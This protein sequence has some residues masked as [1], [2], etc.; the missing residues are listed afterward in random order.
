MGRDK[1]TLLFQGEPLFRRGFALLSQVCSSVFLSCR[2]EQAGDELYQSHPLIVDS[3]PDKG[4]LG[5][6]ES[7]L[8]LNSSCAWLVLPC[9]LPSMK[10]TILQR[11]LDSRTPGFDAVVASHG[12]KLEPLVGV[13][14]PTSA[15]AASANLGRDELSMRMLLKSLNVLEMPF[16]D[17]GPFRNVNT[18]DDLEALTRHSSRLSE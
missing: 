15:S 14:E 11:L 6:L 13:Y 2:P 9:D 1:A 5:A 17:P 10:A 12:G 8:Q 16:E 18:P 7:A 4:P 3:V